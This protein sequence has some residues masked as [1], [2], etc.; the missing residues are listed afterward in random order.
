MAWR[1]VQNGVVGRIGVLVRYNGTT[2]DCSEHHLTSSRICE[3]LIVTRKDSD[4]AKYLVSAIDGEQ[5]QAIVI[6]RGNHI[7]AA[8]EAARFHPDVFF[9]INPYCKGAEFTAQRKDF[10]THDF[11]ISADYKEDG[12]YVQHARDVIVKRVN[13]FDLNLPRVY[14]N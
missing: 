10:S 14:I 11:L 8:C 2:A 4:M 13:K 1:I 7:R 3:T 9:G 5:E 6:V 12:Q